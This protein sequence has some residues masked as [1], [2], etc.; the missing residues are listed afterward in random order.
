MFRFHLGKKAFKPKKPAVSK[1]LRGYHTDVLSI[2]RSKERLDAENNEKH[3]TG[4]SHL[5]QHKS[6][7]IKTVECYFNKEGISKNIT[8]RSDI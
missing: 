3:S 1:T 8:I 7:L 4:K 2:N 6:Y 5:Q